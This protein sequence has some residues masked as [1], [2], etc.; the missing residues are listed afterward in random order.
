MNKAVLEGLLFVVGEDG[1]SLDQISDVLDIK[2]EEAK[3]LVKELKSDY[4]S[5]ERGLRI[6]FLGNK[7]KLTTKSEH[8][9][10]YSKLIENPITNKLSQAALETLAIIAYNEPITRIKI[11]NLRGVSTVQ[12]IRKLAAKG[13]IKESGRSDLPG[14]PILYETTDEFLDYFGL[15]SL[16][17]LPDMSV[18][19]NKSQEEDSDD[20]DLYSSKYR[21][22]SQ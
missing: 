1:L 15:S 8:K 17:D 9:D 22:D 20:E 7:F 6:D 12:I 16:K 18:F 4:E 11:D 3:E 5:E 21:E 19:I 13:L 10:Y 2:V 14:R